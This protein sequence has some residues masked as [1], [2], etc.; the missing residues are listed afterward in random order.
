MP[1]LLLFQ[2]EPAALGFDLAL[3]TFFR[4]SAEKQV[5]FLQEKLRRWTEIMKLCKTTDKS[6]WNT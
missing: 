1:L 2:I 6:D 4:A 5:L 3:G